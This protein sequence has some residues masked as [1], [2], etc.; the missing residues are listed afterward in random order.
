MG[1]LT[2]LHVVDGVL[3]TTSADKV[4]LAKGLEVVQ[5]SI[6]QINQS[7][8]LWFE[9]SDRSWLRD[10][11]FNVLDLSLVEISDISCIDFLVFWFECKWLF[12]LS[13]VDTIVNSDSILVHI[14]RVQ[15]HQSKLRL[16]NWNN[17]SS[18]WLTIAKAVVWI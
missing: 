8:L 4:D 18:Y 11:F 2:S 5:V 1:S 13:S 6:G 9:S 7:N 14:F 3:A 16:R 15:V 12:K 17:H 10:Q